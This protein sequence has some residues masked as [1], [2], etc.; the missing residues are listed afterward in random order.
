MLVFEPFS[1]ETLK[2]VQPYIN[3]N[4]SLCS[5]LYGGAIF[6]WHSDDASFC[7]W[8]DTFVIHQS[9]GGQKAFSWPVGKDVD[10][11]IDMILDCSRKNHIPLRFYAVEEEI[12]EKI[13]KDP[14]LKKS[15]WSFDER[16][17]DYI[18]SFPETLTFSGKK[19]SGQRNH[20]NKFKRLYGEPDVKRM[21]EEDLTEVYDFLYKYEK[22]HTFKNKLERLE[23]EHTKRLLS[24]FED[25]NLLGAYIKVDGEIAAIGLGE[26]T[27]DMLLIH[28]EKALKKYEGIYPTMYQEL[29]RL[30]DKMSL[31]KINIINRE[32]DSGDL[33]LRTSKLQYKPIGKVNKYMVHVNS[34]SLKMEKNPVIKKGEVVITGIFERDK[35]DYL[36]LNTDNV[37]NRFWG[38]DYREDP[39]ITGE[40]NEDTF[41]NSVMHDMKVGDSINFAIRLSEEGEMIGE[42]ILWN[43]TFD[44][45]AE[46]GVRIKREYHGNGY[47]REAFGG[48][49][50][51]AE[52]A[53][54]LKVWAR[55]FKENEASRKMIEKNGLKL[56]REDE[57]FYYFE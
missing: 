40:I 20:I 17:S 2:K 12:L 11:M 57:K 33:G 51:F 47:G 32:D 7:V 54:G 4:T 5:D 9:V 43:F 8:N 18:Y 45:T 27:G 1:L 29:V 14:R 31:E 28:V 25:L 34:P 55:C 50:G 22:E 35:E 48:I 39:F 46:L 36:A 6:M 21:A 15:S 19:Y 13:K 42:G 26:I 3:M 10:G 23:F 52:K 41:Y 44:G 30:A 53:L 56:A 38:Y 16:W 24:V 37:N 49:L